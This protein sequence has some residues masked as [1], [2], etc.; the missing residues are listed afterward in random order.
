[1]DFLFIGLGGVG[2]RHLR[3]LKSILGDE[4][5]I[6]AYRIRGEDHV[7][8][9]K[10]NIVEG[11]RLED[12]YGIQVYRDLDHALA[13]RPDVAFVTNPTSQHIPIA[14]RA[15]SHGCHLFIEKP[16]SHSWDG[17]E[18]LIHEAENRKIVGFVA[19]QLRWHPGFI[20]LRTWL[21]EDANWSNIVCTL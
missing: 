16:L 12:E 15:A 10:L 3:N 11:K 8:D 5:R 21:K 20:Q 7:L 4:A 2:Q 6:S 17:I 18:S 19:Y 9:D 1:M 14:A 13:A